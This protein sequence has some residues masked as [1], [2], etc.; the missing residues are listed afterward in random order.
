[1]NM[2]RLVRA[3]CVLFVLAAPS[4]CARA[5]FGLYKGPQPAPGAITA[6]DPVWEP[7]HKESKAGAPPFLIP[8]TTSRKLHRVGTLQISPKADSVV[9]LINSDSRPGLRMMTTSWGL[10]SVLDIGS[11]DPKR[12]LWAVLN[13][14]VTLVQAV[15]P[16]LDGVRDMYA[17]AYSHR[18]T[19]GNQKQVLKAIERELPAS[20]MIAGGDLVEHGRRGALWEEFVRLHEPIRTQ[21]PFLASPGNH[22][23]IWSEEGSANW[24]AVMG[25]PA[26]PG[27]YWFSVDMPESLARFVFLDS[28]LL[29]DPRN[30]Y[31]DSL[32]AVLDNEQL[33]WADSALAVPA[34]WKFVVLH[35][36]L[37]TSGHYLSDWKYDDSNPQETR[38][39]GRLLEMCRR[40]HVTAVLASHEHLYQR[41]YVRG[42]DGTGFWQITSGGGGAPPYSVSDS[43]RRAALA[44]TLPDS[45][46]VT[47]SA[48]TPLYHYCRLVIVRRPKKGEDLVYLDAKGVDRHGRVTRFDHAILSVP[49]KV[50]DKRA[51]LPGT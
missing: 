12:F 25:P 34:R 41:I 18:Y 15:V 31:P 45:S 50:E 30:H 26:E 47:W 17:M 19:G 1:M 23:R 46:T 28:E 20:F 33:R 43:E 36:P 38:R 51:T 13:I 16:K 10:P 42:R 39:R 44:V 5:P 21:V 2:K 6:F 37:V 29:A 3:A 8:G 14:P 35:H 27:K 24:N 40:R 32:E 22:E 11:P 4:G 9:V 7:G 49:P 48:A